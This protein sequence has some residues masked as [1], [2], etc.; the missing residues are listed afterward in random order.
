MIDCGHWQFWLA[1]QQ[2][3]RR[4]SRSTVDHHRRRAV[5]LVT[6]PCPR[7][8]VSSLLRLVL[9]CQIKFD[10]SSGRGWAGDGPLSSSLLCLI[11]EY[12][13]WCLF[14][15]R[16][17]READVH[18]SAHAP[19]WTYVSTLYPYEHLRK[20]ELDWQISRLTKSPIT[21]DTT[22]SMGMSPTTKRIAPL[23]LEINPWKYW[24]RLANLEIDEV[25]NHY[26]HRVVDGYVAYH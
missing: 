2:G 1:G 20:I 19:L 9:V 22:L 23:N 6:K 12:F 3:Q 18:T 4:L 17:F 21:T 16:P 15:V 24:V 8:H 26:R 5:R 14:F 10:S 7:A 11:K 13:S 25:T